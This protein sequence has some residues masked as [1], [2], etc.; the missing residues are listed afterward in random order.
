MNKLPFLQEKSWPRIAKQAG[1]SRYG[2]SEDEALMEDATK[3]LMR[4]IEAKDVA[5]I[6]NAIEALVE[7]IKNQN[8]GDENDDASE[9]A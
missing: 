6:M 7:I 5:M 4:G 1:E 8:S 9:N 2:Y 3:E